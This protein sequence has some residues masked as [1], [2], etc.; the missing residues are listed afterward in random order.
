MLDNG[1][2]HDSINNKKWNKIEMLQNVKDI[3]NIHINLSLM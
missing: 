1:I 3:A 2:E